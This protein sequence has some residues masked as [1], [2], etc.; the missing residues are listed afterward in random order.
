VGVYSYENQWNVYYIP[1]GVALSRKL[2]VGIG[3]SST[4][5]SQSVGLNN[6][7]VPAWGPVSIILG[8]A[9]SV[10]FTNPDGVN[11]PINIYRFDA[12]NPSV[13]SLHDSY[14]LPD[15]RQSSVI[16]ESSE[17][18]WMMSCR[19]QPAENYYIKHAYPPKPGV[20]GLLSPPSGALVNTLQP[21]LDWKDSVPAAHRYQIQIS[22]NNTFTALVTDETHT[23]TSD[24]TITSDLDPG[25][26]YYWRVRAFNI[27]NQEGGWSAIWN[28]R[29]PLEA[30]DLVSPV[31]GVLLPT[32]RPGFDWSDIPGATSYVIQVAAT[33][34][35]STPLVNATVTVSESAMTKDLPLNRTL[36]WRVR[37]KNSAVTGAWS[38]IGTFNTP[39]PPSVPVLTL[40]AN[41]ALVTDY[42]PLLKWKVVTVP[43][44]ATF[45]HYE[46]QVDDDPAFG[47]PAIHVNLNDLNTPEFE[48]AV[49]LPEN[50]KYYWRV[51]S[52][53]TMGHSSA[54]SAVWSFRAALLPPVPVLPV[55]GN[56]EV[57]P[58]P[59][60]DWSD[61]PGAAGYTI[62]IATDSNFAKVVHSG[63]P[64][65]S[66]YVPTADL[67]QSR[68]FYWRV[69]TRGTNGPSAW[70]PSRYFTAP[71]P[72]SVPVLT[73]PAGNA[74]VTDYTPLL[75]WKIVTVPMDTTF[76]HYQVQVDDNSDFSSP[77]LYVNVNTLAT[78][79]F[80]PS[81]NLATNT[82]FHWRVRSVNTDNEASKWS[83]VRTF[84][85]AILPPVPALPNDGSSE[86]TLRPSFD[87]IDV[88]GA[89]GY[90]IQISRNNTFTLVVHTANP[91]ASSYVPT[92]NL[93]ANVV[94]YWRVRTRAANGPSL[95]T[96]T[97]SFNSP[98]PPSIPVLSAPASNARVTDYTPLFT[99]KVVTVPAGVTFDR[100]QIQVDDDPNFGSPAIN[101]NINSLATPQFEPAS[102]LPPNT[103]FYWR[104]RAFNTQ[105]ASSVWSAVRSFRTALV[106]PTLTS[107]QDGA[108]G[109]SRKPT[110]TWNA[111]TGA[112]SYTIQVSTSS[113]FG[114]LII[115]ATTGN[116]NYT[117]LANLPANRLLYWRVRANG[118]LGASAW[119]SRQFTTGP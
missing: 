6:S 51:R 28:F 81:V 1:N 80:E 110:F 15:C 65:A 36:Y 111:V 93:P 13:V 31:E 106:P 116:R 10:L 49:N 42:T 72:P 71:N 64:L 86:L 53:N 69:R 102:N 27:N 52:Y 59:T 48:P 91:V 108:E 89:T 7:T 85:T 56:Y 38:A 70:S 77:T 18:H 117:P 9:N 30:P 104:V 29:T 79:E 46:L 26:R 2:G 40:P 109:V 74:L 101:S 4:S 103:R 35:F 75:K 41:T 100:Y 37:A 84:R 58:R 105:G 22:T 54:W 3:G 68:Y 12:G 21:A 97:R 57:S 88:P 44:S 98:N 8:G 61:V 113:S 39:N 92:V 119:S 96:N 78:P 73:Q 33:N 114:T 25:K 82:K 83:A 55:V 34:Q 90:A 17:Y 47:S 11:G 23:P 115:N 76:S 63:S 107:P 66:T 67:P 32:A 16:Y 24:F 50:M 43:A 45:D 94:L 19:D 99:W 5:F 112:T 20:P 62:Q 14:T 60:F 87:W 118:G 95:W